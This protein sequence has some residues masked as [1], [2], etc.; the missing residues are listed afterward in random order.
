MK[1]EHEMMIWQVFVQLL[2]LESIWWINCRI[3]PNQRDLNTLGS[4]IAF[5]ALITIRERQVAV[6]VPHD[7]NPIE[8][9]FF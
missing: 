1:F 5:G 7:G 9:R 4:G 8:G 2:A 3:E 6:G